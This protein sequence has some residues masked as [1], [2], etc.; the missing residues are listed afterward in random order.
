MTSF[1]WLYAT[2]VAANIFYG[3]LIFWKFVKYNSRKTKSNNIKLSDSF[4]WYKGI[5]VNT[6]LRAEHLEV[7]HIV[8]WMHISIIRLTS[9]LNIQFYSKYMSKI[10]N[11]GSQIN[12]F[13]LNE[14]TEM[15]HYMRF[16]SF[17]KLQA[18][19]ILK[20]HFSQSLTPVLQITCVIQNHNGSMYMSQLWQ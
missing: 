20:N 10:S 14:F 8:C 18:L 11:L 12:M 13:N 15:F 5:T 9:K 4:K 6:V 16:D 1:T 17:H 2:F 3:I 7:D 19:D